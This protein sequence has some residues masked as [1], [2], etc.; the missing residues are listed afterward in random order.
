MFGSVVRL[1]P[2]LG[3]R[4]AHLPRAGLVGPSG[5][6]PGA[7]GVQPAGPGPRRG[8]PAGLPGGLPPLFLLFAVSV[9]GLLL[10]VSYTWMKG[11]G[12]DFL[13]LLHAVTVI[14]MLLWLPFGKF[15][16]IFQRPAQ[17]AV[18]FYRDVAE[19]ET[20]ARCAVPRAVR[21]PDPRPR[22]D[23]GGGRV[24]VPVR[25][26]RAAGGHYQ[27][28]CPACRRKM[29]ALAQHA[30]W[31]PEPTEAVG[32]GA[33]ARH[34]G[35]AGQFGPLRATSPAAGWTPGS[36][37]TSWSRPTAASAASSAASSSR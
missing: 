6:P 9:T 29:L 36:T 2:R 32:D 35:A 17:L 28:V 14:A 13:A 12:Y 25:H 3:R 22:P 7:P 33:E 31:H 10:T 20:P 34:P 27:H 11:Y 4:G 1:R 16:H 18:K 24:G 8:R 26:A 15:F 37:R 23:P 21:H 5:H 30:A 19:E